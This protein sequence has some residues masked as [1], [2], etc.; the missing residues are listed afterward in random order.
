MNTSPSSPLPSVTRPAALSVGVLSYRAPVPVR[1]RHERLAGPTLYPR[2]Q[3]TNRTM[4]S[5]TLKKLREGDGR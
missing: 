3:G 1:V 2:T 4:L 5:A